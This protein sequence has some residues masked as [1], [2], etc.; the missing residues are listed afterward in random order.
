MMRFMHR[1]DSAWEMGDLAYELE[2][3]IETGAIKARNLG[4][5]PGSDSYAAFMT[6]FS[7]RVRSKKVSERRDVMGEVS[8]A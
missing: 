4:L 3:T 8:L 5:A 2:D 7:R 1:D 6:A